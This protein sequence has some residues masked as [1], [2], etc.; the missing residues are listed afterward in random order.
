MVLDCSV[1]AL[2]SAL[3]SAVIY[4]SRIAQ[5]LGVYVDRDHERE[6]LRNGIAPEVVEMLKVR[7]VA[8]DV[9]R[10]DS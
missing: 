10:S 5:I 7:M 8:Q 4:S 1:S 2:E 9:A 3:S 6:N